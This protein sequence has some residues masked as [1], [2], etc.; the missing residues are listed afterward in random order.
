MAGKV[1]AKRPIGYGNQEIDRGQVFDL[2]GARNDEKL[3]RLG[4]IAPFEGKPKDLVECAACGAQFIG[5]D[6]RRGHYEKR[7]VRVLSPE[8]EDARIDREERFL[9]EVAP[10]RM[11]MTEA[12][13]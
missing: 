4:Y 13:R 1:W 9:N 11:E 7:H 5:G 12:S 8:E 3:L 2:A 6:E 10:L